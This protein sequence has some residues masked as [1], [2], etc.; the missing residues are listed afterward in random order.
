MR[1]KDFKG[2]IEELIAIHDE[3]SPIRLK[4][5]RDYQEAK[6]AYLDIKRNINASEV[7]KAQALIRKEGQEEAYRSGVKKLQKDVKEKLFEVRKDFEEHLSEFY[8]P[9]GKMLDEDVVSLLNSGI[10]LSADEIDDLF[11]ANLH[12]PTMLRLLSDFCDRQG[13]GSEMAKVYGGA[14]KDGGKREM[15]L[16]ATIEEL[17]NNSISDDS[18]SIRTWGAG[19]GAFETMAEKAK[20]GM[21]ELSI[22]PK[23]D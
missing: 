6:Q 14:T 1:H 5:E 9:D 12:N 2:Y 13:I 17:V 8:R 10:R 4:L 19:N 22:K 3:Y 16:F 11:K 20:A 23:N 15:K 21:D 18:Y 7:D